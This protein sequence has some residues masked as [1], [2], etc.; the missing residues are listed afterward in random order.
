MYRSDW[1]QADTKI[2]LSYL[3]AHMLFCF[4]TLHIIYKHRNDSNVRQKQ[5]MLT[6]DRRIQNK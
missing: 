2:D 1:A 6:S 5:H 4:V 3:W